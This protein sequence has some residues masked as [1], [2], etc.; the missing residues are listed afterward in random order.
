MTLKEY[1]EDNNIS[2]KHMALDFNVSCVAVYRWRN[3][4]RIPRAKIL[5]QILKW[6]NGAVQ[7]SDFYL[8]STN[9]KGNMPAFL[10]ASTKKES[11]NAK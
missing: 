1:L 6:S 5:L 3:S 10:T 4:L 7:P 9:K 8:K 11:K 2:I